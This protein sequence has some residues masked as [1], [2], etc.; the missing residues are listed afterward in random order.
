MLQVCLS[1]AK[2]EIQILQEYWFIFC[3]IGKAAADED[4]IRWMQR[5]VVLEAKNDPFQSN[6]P[7]H[8]EWFRKYQ[9]A[10]YKA[11]CT[12]TCNTKIQLLQYEIL[13]FQNLNIWKK[14][15]NT[16]NERLYA[17]RKLDVDTRPKI[18][19]RITSIRS[20]NAEPNQMPRKYMELQTIFDSS[21]SQ[22][23]LKI[24]L[25]SSVVRQVTPSM[26]SYQPHRISLESTS[27]NDHEV[28]APLCATIQ[29]M[30]EMEI[31]PYNHDGRARSGAP[32]WLNNIC[33]IIENEQ[34]HK[35]IRLFLVTVI[36]NLREWF[37][38]YAIRLT[39]TILKFLI[40]WKYEQ[41]DATIIFLCCDLLEW[42][43]KYRIQTDDEIRF[44]NML[45][46]DLMT[47]AWNDHKDVFSRNLEIIRSLIEKW[48]NCLQVPTQLLNN[49]LK[50]TDYLK[51]KENI[52][53]IHLNGIVLSNGLI[54]WNDESRI[55][56]LQTLSS[57][58][59][60][61]H[62]IVHQPAAQVLG[63]ALH[64]IIIKQQSGD[65]QI[66]GFLTA[67]TAKLDRYCLRDD[68]KFL[69][70][71]YGLHNYYEPIVDRFLVRIAGQIPRTS[72]LPKKLYL[73]MFLSRVN[74]HGDQVFKELSAIKIIELLESDEFRLI[75]LHIVN[76]SLPNLIHKIDHIV[77]ALKAMQL[78]SK[79]DCRSIIYEIWI[80]IRQNHLPQNKLYESA[81]AAL[82]IG[83]NDSDSN[84][85]NRIYQYWTETE[86]PP[87]KIH[88][89]LLY[90]FKRLYHPECQHE[91][92][93]YCVQFLL[94]PSIQ[95]NNSK[96]ILNNLRHQNENIKLTEYKVDT[97][98]TMQ[99][100]SLQIPLFTQSQQVSTVGG[101]PPYL[102]SA[103]SNLLFDPTQDPSTLHQ[104]TS[105]FSLQTQSSLLFTVPTQPLDRRSYRTIP[106]A[107][108]H[109]SQAQ[110]GHLRSYIIRDSQKARHESA[111]RAIERNEYN[112]V[113]NEQGKHRSRQVQLYRRY[114]FGDSPDF[115]LNSLAFLLPLQNLIRC[116][117][118]LARHS[119][120]AIFAAIY[121]EIAE[122]DQADFGRQLGIAITN[123]LSR[124]ESC[125]PL[126]FGVLT[127]ISLTHGITFNFQSNV[128]NSACE[129][130][131]LTIDAILLY[132]Y[133]L[134][135]LSNSVDATA[136]WANLANLNRKLSETDIVA[137]I[138]ANKI[139]TNPMLSA[140]IIAA[141]HGEY[142]R[143][144]RTLYAYLKLDTIPQ[145]ESDFGYQLHYECYA[146]MARWEE[147]EG[148]VRFQIESEDDLWTNEWNKQYLLPH[149]MQAN[150]HCA[151]HGAHQTAKAFTHNIESWLRDSAR[152][153]FIEH[154]FSDPL[155]LLFIAND[156][157]LRAKFYSDRYF[158][159]FLTE[160][161]KTS[162]L[163]INLRN[164]KL[165]NL[166]C[167]AEM[168]DYALLLDEHIDEDTLN[169]L[170]QRWEHA[171]LNQTDSIQL[172]EMLIAYRTYITDK[173]LDRWKSQNKDSNNR[174]VE[175]TIGMHFK[176]IE[177]AVHQSNIDLSHTVLKRIEKLIP[178][179]E[180][181]SGKL[182]VQLD[183]AEA[184]FMYLSAMK[185]RLQPL[186]K[187][188]SLTECWE[189]L[190]EIQTRYTD[191]LDIHPD[192]NLKVHTQIGDIL[193]RIVD[194]DL[195]LLDQNFQEQ[196]NKLTG[197]Q[198]DCK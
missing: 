139:K 3:F 7:V 143:A 106:T 71:L 166:R 119:F 87:E 29:H 151:I 160:W 130:N 44:A 55:M 13:L 192:I 181:N 155:M 179:Y 121:Q 76:K 65:N 83:L 52:C 85:R 30:F 104:T 175:R 8:M 193:L 112:R 163:S 31:T 89:R 99:N 67:L 197:Q 149:Y 16:A 66:D 34:T 142:S 5:V 198:K 129:A 51:S 84:I 11:C 109:S 182:T 47:H 113:A 32:A 131:A 4:L 187:V 126:L 43:A 171:Q 165:L 50:S 146:E 157:F 14:I 194:V 162:T 6:N 178:A 137:S 170:G 86:C 167:I 141:G 125:D 15:I 2:F 123:L 161:N 94:E 33:Q 41:I 9:C 58:L 114:R 124:S 144:V 81:T 101:T 103:E 96:Q 172:W 24:D 10:A 77:P 188:K 72:A 60:S 108:N 118:K 1:Y 82:L 195:R 176:L 49:S 54:P 92:V 159:H 21:L 110:F 91:F 12:I 186:E 168:H 22:D 36:D 48:R 88:E 37:A 147:L 148:N 35:N 68:S 40:S 132:E 95:A 133:K 105:S 97:A 138:Y 180:L 64:E 116:D 111:N 177:V 69:K 70:I 79:S 90:I 185:K 59:D 164:R 45:I 74:T 140:A 78:S 189:K 196:I 158:E 153:E 25:S 174:L 191:L 136:D 63:M 73:E 120:I 23:V 145:L 18:K 53:G 190:S 19:K 135:N 100:S 39:R 20:L 26:P 122:E 134:I 150:A 61:E 183:V 27:I 56:Y 107:T 57:C 127:E 93:T 154:N 184:H 42:D 38:H 117:A 46:E 75:A 115:F 156:D 17:M 80:Y 173:I 28:M 152:C 128:I 98:G 169:R 62:P 102:R